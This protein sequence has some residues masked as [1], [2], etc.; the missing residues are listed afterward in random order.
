MR[1]HHSDTRSEPGTQVKVASANRKGT[2]RVG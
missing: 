2:D 1:K